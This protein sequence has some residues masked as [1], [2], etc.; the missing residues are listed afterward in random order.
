[1]NPR[2]PRVALYAR[3]SSDGQVKGRTIASQIEAL[4]RRVAGD[5]FA[6]EPDLRFLDDGYSGATLVR[7]ALERLRDLAAV[8]G[9]DRLYVHAPDRLARSYVY[10]MLLVDELRR[11]GVELV[12]LN[13]QIGQT[14]EDQLLLQ[15]QGMMAEYER[16][17]ILERVRRGKLHA[18]RAGR[19]SAV[20]K[21]PYGY[22]YV[23]KAEGSGVARWEIHPEEAAVI[24][25][26]FLWVGQEGCSLAEVG[27]RLKQQGTRTQTG[28]GG[29]LSRTIWGML[30]NAAYKGTALFGKTV[31]G[32]RRARLRPRRGAEHPRRLR[33]VLKTPPEEQIPIPVPALVSEEL[34]A[35]VQERL[36]ENKKRNR[37]PS[38]A[39]RYLL[40]GLVVCQQCGYAYCGQARTC[41]RPDQPT[42]RYQYYSCTGSM[43]GRC[44]RER[45][46]WNRSVRMELLDA[47]VWDDVRSL[48]AEPGRVAAEYR[49]R[50]EGRPAPG[51]SCGDPLGKLTQ[52]AQHRISR[53]ID[54]YEDGLMEKGEFEPRILRARERL[55]QLEAEAQREEE[56]QTAEQ[57]LQHLIGEL[58]KFAERV[59]EG[60][61][62]A[63]GQT[64]REVIRALVKRVEIDEAE[65][66]MVYKVSPCPF[67]E[68]PERGHFQDRERRYIVNP[69]P[70]P[71]FLHG[72]SSTHGNDGLAMVAGTQMSWSAR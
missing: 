27:R 70:T 34:F 38:Q 29:W 40:Q 39:V 3:V 37:R 6:L 66:R 69:H 8:G 25:Q 26:M 44:D 48:L 59:R 30:T 16:A 4:A 24:R 12:F 7:P 21:A 15:M 28:R 67:V 36:L 2:S 45:V 63:D 62:G 46:C 41:Q 51:E 54:A 65:V 32:E 57:E 33:S 22:R 56:R 64:R 47:A 17:K 1:M 23:S 11:C 71:L 31:S 20:G 19:V 53:L 5:G 58:E 52:A 43:F 61:G 60:L 13:H 35:A 50:L 9:F 55:A 14:P 18:A 10:Q 72:A 68:G 49:R 42:R